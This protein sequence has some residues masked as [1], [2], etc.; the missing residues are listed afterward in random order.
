MEFQID[1]NNS[2]IQD[3]LFL[4]NVLGAKWTKTGSNKYPPFEVLKLDVKDFNQLEKILKMVDNH[5][6]SISTALISFDPPT[7]YIDLLK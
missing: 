2:E 6:K 7:I 4:V 5:F 1:F 3:D